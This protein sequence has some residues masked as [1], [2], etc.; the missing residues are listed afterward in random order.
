MR[1]HKHVWRVDGASVYKDPFGE[2]TSLNLQCEKCGKVKRKKIAIKD[3]S[4]PIE[5]RKAHVGF[6]GEWN[7]LQFRGE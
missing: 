4:A 5:R 6:L 2:S 7:V 1:I 3:R